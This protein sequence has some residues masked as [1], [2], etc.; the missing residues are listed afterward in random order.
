[1]SVYICLHVLTGHYGSVGGQRKGC[2]VGFLSFVREKI[3]SF[4]VFRKSL[5]GDEEG[6]WSWVEREREREYESGGE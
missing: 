3:I 4:I 1:M 2:A 5:A 6:G